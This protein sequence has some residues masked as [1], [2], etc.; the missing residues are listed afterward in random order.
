M[1]NISLLIA[2]VLSCLIAFFFIPKHV[3]QTTIDETASVEIV[4]DKPFKDI[5]K[6]IRKGNFEEQVLR[7]NNAELIS[8]Q[9]VDRRFNIE[10][11]LKKDRYWE[12]AGK[13]VAQVQVDDPHAGRIQVELVEEVFFAIDRIEV[14]T[15]LNR[16]LD[17]GV[18]D[19]QQTICLTPDGEQTRVFLANRIILKRFIPPFMKEQ[20]RERVRQSAERS[21]NSM[22]QA[23]RGL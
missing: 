10:R 23:I 11:P 13:I 9:W 7:I 17:I 22:E 1:K 21:V 5:Q 8:K 6:A 3:F 16:P 20:I 15:R 19:I 12:L 4:I 2:F 18:S 14:H